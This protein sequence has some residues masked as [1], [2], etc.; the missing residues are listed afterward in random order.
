MHKI[1][2]EDNFIWDEHKLVMYLYQCMNKNINPVIDFFLEGPSAQAT[3]LY[4]ILDLFCETNNYPKEQITIQ[5]GN[6]VETHD[7]YCIK[8]N[9]DYWYEIKLIQDWIKTNKVVTNT[10]PT[11]HFGN[12][13]GRATWARAWVAAHLYNN[14]RDKTLQTFHS[15]F[16][17]N[18]VIPQSAGVYDTLGLDNLNKYGCD[19]IT[20]VTK[21]LQS[22]PVVLKKD[23]EANNPYIAPSNKNYPIQYPTNM[24]ILD[25]YKHF[26]ID[27][28]TE[29]RV[30]GNLFFCTEKIWRPI[31]ARRP[32]IVIGPENFLKNL[33][34]LGFKTFNNFW[35]EGYD[36]YGPTERL[37]NIIQLIDI[38]AAKSITKLNAMTSQMQ[39]IF[40]NNYKV[41]CSLTYQHIKETFDE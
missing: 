33:Q 30:D 36:E 41:F 14:H 2:S 16:H 3:G 7:S 35:D 8:K 38:L 1:I 18:Y 27:I 6:A 17:K 26:C 29:T 4:Q 37:K 40:E 24:N 13:V 39:N 9:Y 34:K 31:V 19:I 12:F 11:K 23:F 32:F 20:E 25:Q 10:I 28:V 22:C 5:T 21:F 15:G